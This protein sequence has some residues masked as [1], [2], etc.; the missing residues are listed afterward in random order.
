LQHPELS[1]EQTLRLL[2]TLYGSSP[3]GSSEQQQTTQQ[4]LQLTQQTNL[5][6]AEKLQAVEVLYMCSP[7]NSQENEQAVEMLLAIAQ[8]SDLKIEE[9]ITIFPLLYDHNLT[10]STEGQE[11]LQVLA[12]L[13]QKPEHSQQQQIQIAQDLYEASL[14]RSAN[15]ELGIQTLWKQAQDDTLAP[16]IRLKA[17]TTPLVVGDANYPDRAQAVR[18]I[19][20]LKQG[21]EARAYFEEYW[22]PVLTN[23]RAEPS[24]VPALVELIQQDVLPLDARDE[25]YRILKQM[26]PQFGNV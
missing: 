13:L 15:R 22:Q 23:N 3:N 6:F 1:F 24:D 25:I 19:L 21:E 11:A 26:V 9:A 14:P 4:L 7:L 18:V 17:A 16:E 2:E 10:A 12:R 5:S 20:T 8:A